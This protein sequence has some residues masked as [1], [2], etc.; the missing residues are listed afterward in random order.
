MKKIYLHTVLLLISLFTP[1]SFSYST[2][3]PESI[4]I[5]PNEHGLMAKNVILDEIK[6]AHTSIQMSIYQIR[7]AD[8][9]KALCEKSNAGIGVDVLYESIPYTHAFNQ[10]TG[11]DTDLFSLLHNSNVQLH[12]RPE[13]LITRFPKGHYHARYIILDNSL[14]LLTTGNFDKTTF[15]HCR[16]FG[17]VFTKEKNET[18]FTALAELFMR[19]IRNQSISDLLT[20]ETLIIGPHF[21]REL[22]A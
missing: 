14:F 16:D 6:S 5:Y 17:V 20:Y 19:D 12:Q 8:I 4:I 21:Q 22:V 9:V 2:V 3:F 11:D 7:D 13:N 15:D 10:K 18:I 1:I